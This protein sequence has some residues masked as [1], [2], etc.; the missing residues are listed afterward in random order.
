MSL[1]NPCTFLLV[2]ENTWNAFL[3]KSEL[4]QY[5][6]EKQI[7]PF[8]TTLNWLF[9]DT[10]CYLVIGSFDW[11]QL[12]GVYCILK[13]NIYILEIYYLKINKLKI[14]FPWLLEKNQFMSD[15]KIK[16]LRIQ[17]KINFKANLIELI[18]FYPPW[19]IRKPL[20]F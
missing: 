7:M 8:K 3:T 18:N 4:S 20:V 13:W 11:K 5:R 6:T 19:N 9:N 15:D 1:E 14:K 16:V 2:E 17:I 12:Q 10:W